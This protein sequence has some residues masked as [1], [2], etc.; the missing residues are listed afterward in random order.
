MNLR[1]K[2]RKHLLHGSQLDAALLVGRNLTLFRPHFRLGHDFPAW[3]ILG[4]G[5]SIFLGGSLFT[6]F[7]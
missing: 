3:R 7:R 4:H 6:A 5:G 1:Q 2:Q